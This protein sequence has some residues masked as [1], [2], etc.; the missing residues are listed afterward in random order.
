MLRTS[1]RSHWEFFFLVFLKPSLTAT[2]AWISV[3][4]SQQVEGT[5][6]H[7]CSQ[8]LR[9]ASMQVKMQEDLPAP[10]AVKAGSKEKKITLGFIPSV[11]KMHC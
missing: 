5:H 10:A 2:G 4:V 1:W 7:P 8:T 11:C 3:S 9:A 6:I